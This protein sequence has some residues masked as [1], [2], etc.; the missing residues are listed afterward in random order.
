[1]RTKCVSL[2]VC[3]WIGSFLSCSIWC[4]VGIVPHTKLKSIYQ[5]LHYHDYKSISW[6]HFYVFDRWKETFG[7]NSLA[8]AVGTNLRRRLHQE[9]DVND[10]D[11]DDNNNK[12]KKRG[13]DETVK[14]K[15]SLKNNIDRDLRS[16]A[17]NTNY[18][19]QTNWYFCHCRPVLHFPLC[20]IFTSILLA[21]VF[22]LV[23]I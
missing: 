2:C 3:V 8:H 21:I 6:K 18:I 23:R 15:K 7:N 22:V 17:M 14:K 5:Q 13:K 12:K 19:W 4:A 1:M 9:D 20:S 10:S 16:T 11:N